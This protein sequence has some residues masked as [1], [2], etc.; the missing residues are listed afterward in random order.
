MEIVLDSIE[1]IFI[2]TKNAKDNIGDGLWWR[3]QLDANWE[4]IPSAHRNK[5]K[6]YESGSLIKFMTM[7]ATRQSGIVPNAEDY[8]GWLSLARHHGLP[9]RLLD[10][11]ESPLIALWFA[12]ANFDQKKKDAKLYSLNGFK[13]NM[14]QAKLPYHVVGA[15][16]RGQEMCMRAF[17]HPEQIDDENWKYPD[18]AEKISAMTIQHTHS[19]MMTQFS[20]F[21]IHDTTNPLNQLPGKADFLREYIIPHEVVLKIHGQ[22]HEIGIRESIVYPDLD[23]LAHELSH[24]KFS[25]L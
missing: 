7:A 14:D 23:H 6:L 1:K 17:L 12:T 24:Y 15:S 19:R 13:L 16:E 2:I 9:T 21:T 18:F 8:A 25:N 4:L 3:G 11:S 5:D 20:G 10:W 22:L